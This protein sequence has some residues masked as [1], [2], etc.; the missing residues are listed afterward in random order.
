MPLRREGSDLAVDDQRALMRKAVEEIAIDRRDGL[1]ARR[2]VAGALQTQR[3]RGIREMRSF[4]EPDVHAWL[5]QIDAQEG[6]ALRRIEE[7]R[8][9]TMT[10]FDADA[11]VFARPGRR[12]I[13]AKRRRRRA[14][15]GRLAGPREQEQREGDKTGHRSFQ[16]DARPSASRPASISSSAAFAK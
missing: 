7:P 9:L 5:F 1:R 11:N 2:D 15:C 4:G 3:R 10:P 14:D 8:E 16:R 6:Q 12:L 13:E